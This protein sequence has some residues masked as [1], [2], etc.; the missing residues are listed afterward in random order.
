LKNKKLRQSFLKRIKDL[1][2]I[3]GSLEFHKELDQVIHKVELLL[4]VSES[5]EERL[6]DLEIHVN[7]LT[8]L[9][10]TLCTDKLKMKVGVLK[11]LIK[12]IEKEAIKDSQIMHLE[13]L[14]HSPDYQPSKPKPLHHQE[15][16]DPWE[17]IS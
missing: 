9:L 8:R 17:E 4:K 11:R 1:E 16:N 2:N 14:Y 5:S 7:L 13:S 12:R 15:K 6:Q 3:Q 10:T